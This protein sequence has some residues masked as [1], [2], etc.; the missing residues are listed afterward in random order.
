MANRLVKESAKDLIYTAENDI[1]T[2]KEL[3]IG[4]SYPADRKYNIICFHAIQA[5]E[6][7]LK[8]YIICNNIKITKTHNLDY[9]HKVIVKID[10]SFSEIKNDCLLLN[11]LTPSLKYNSRKL[12]TKQVMDEILRSLEVIC[13][14]PP[15]K[16]MRDT[17]S[18][19]NNYTIVDDV[20]TGT[21]FP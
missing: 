18:K 17:F 7:L 6:K 20:V 4:T 14:F 1:I 16:V 19:N 2:V 21:T 12:I 10:V 13:N 8:G 3:I 11:M 15:I 9:L 5:V